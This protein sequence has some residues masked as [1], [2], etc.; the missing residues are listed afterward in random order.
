MPSKPIKV[1][2]TGGIGAGKSI[3]CEIFKILSVPVYD[4]DSRAKTLMEE[5]ERVISLMIETF[6]PDSYNSQGK[7]NRKYLAEKVFPDAT[8]LKEINQIVHPAVEE[9]FVEWVSNQDEADY[10]LKEAAL[11]VETGTYKKLDALIMVTAPEHI[12]I[13]RVLSRDNHRTIEDIRAIIDKQLAEEKKKE[14]S[15][16]V[17][18]NNDNVLLIPQILKIHDFFINFDRTN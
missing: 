14:V 2:I 1:G 13:Q 4:A 15:K 10:I 9:D 3:A 16:F 12:R 7:L 11:L 17:I 8:K 18:I 6:G 5:S